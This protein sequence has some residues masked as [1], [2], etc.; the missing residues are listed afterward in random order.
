[1]KNN[2][3]KTL[4]DMEQEFRDLFGREEFKRMQTRYYIYAPK[5]INYP[6]WVEIE[7]QRK[8]NEL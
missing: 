8:V 4:Q 2:K 5:S 7:L 6:R 3:E 1:M